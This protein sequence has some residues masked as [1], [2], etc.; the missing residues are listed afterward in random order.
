VYLIERRMGVAMDARQVSELR[1]LLDEVVRTRASQHVAQTLPDMTP[2]GLRAARRAH[3]R[4]LEAY[5]RAL[6]GHGWPL[7]RKMRQDLHLQR[8]LCDASRG[9]PAY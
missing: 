1:G 4:A 5:A 7:P 8:S 6:E 2:E 9:W 3:L